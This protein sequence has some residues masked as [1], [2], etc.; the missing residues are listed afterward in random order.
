MPGERDAPRRLPGRDRAPHDL[1]PT[2]D[3]FNDPAADTA[4]HD[5]GF[6]LIPSPTECDLSGHQRAI[7][8]VN[9]RKARSGVARTV[10]AFTTGVQGAGVEVLVTDLLLEKSA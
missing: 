8:S 6:G 9:R 1:A 4:L 7:S 5:D 2:A 3:C 10:T